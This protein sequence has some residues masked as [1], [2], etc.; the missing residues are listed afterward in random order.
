[1]K[2]GIDD[3]SFEDGALQT[4]SYIRPGKLF[5]GNEAIIARRIGKIKTVIISELVQ[6]VVALIQG[7]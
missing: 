1:M 3:T 4:R 5:T 2:I 7:K 6:K